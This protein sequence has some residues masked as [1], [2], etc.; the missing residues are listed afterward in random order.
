MPTFGK[1]SKLELMTLNGALIEML[2]NAIDYYDFT[3]LQGFRN[4]EKQNRAYD[5][6]KSKLRFPY[7]KHNRYPSRA[8]DIV[9]WYRN[10]PHIHWDDIDAFYQLH[11]VITKIASDHGVPLIWGGSWKDFKDYPHYELIEGWNDDE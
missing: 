9:P 2:S 8:C 4:A 3:I 1:H 5:N 6:G 7:S 10:K 11:Y